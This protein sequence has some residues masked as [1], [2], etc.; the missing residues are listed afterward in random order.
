METALITALAAV[1]GSIVGGSATIATAWITQK[2]Q[3]KRELAN[4]EI[5]KREALYTDF[6]VECS[7]LYIHSFQHNLE[8]P[9]SMMPAYSLKNRM[10]LS[11]SEAVIEAADHILKRILDQYFDKNLSNDEMRN[12]VESG[13]NDPLKEFSEACRKDLKNF[14]IQS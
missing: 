5:R 9:E 1:F 11:S 4:A 12:I 2:T 10:T 6:I 14:L 7:R 13:Q 3:I 8:G